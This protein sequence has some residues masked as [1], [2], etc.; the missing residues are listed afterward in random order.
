MGDKYGADKRWRTIECVGGQ[1]SGAP[2]AIIMEMRLVNES[3]DRRPD[4]VVVGWG[5]NFPPSKTF[6]F[7]IFL[8][9]INF[10]AV[11]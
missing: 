8:D 10:F 7:Y 5:K 2:K 11:V 1:I 9:V 3:V 6:C 4:R